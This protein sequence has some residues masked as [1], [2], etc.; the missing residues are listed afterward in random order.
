[1]QQA[2]AVDLPAGLE[3]SR[4]T[5]ERAEVEANIIVTR[6]GEVREGDLLLPASCPEP[7]SALPNRTT[8]QGAGVQDVFDA[9]GR[10]RGN[11][12]GSLGQGSLLLI[13]TSQVDRLNGGVSLRGEGHGEDEPSPVVGFA[14]HRLDR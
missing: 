9:E 8:P 7:H 4:F 12:P 10:G 13:G 2:V 5:A 14:W 1:M 6:G 11:E 3:Q